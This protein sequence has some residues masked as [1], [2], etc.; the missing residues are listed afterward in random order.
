MPSGGA[1]VRSGPAPDPNALRRERD[2]SEWMRLPASGCVEPPPVWPL[3]AATKRER[4]LWER[5][6]RRPQAIV[7]EQ[8]GQEEEVALYV[9]NLAR[10]EKRDSPVN[11][12]TLVRQMADSLGLT[13]PGL[14]AN[15]WLIVGDEAPAR[16]VEARRSSRDR[17]TVVTDA[18]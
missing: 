3:T 14:K 16:P 17:L 4:E 15:K 9:R 8:R 11:Q 7:W 5:Q 2:S 13:T 12:G 10:A 18:G 6:W 1:R